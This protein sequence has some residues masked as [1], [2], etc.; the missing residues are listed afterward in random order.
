MLKTFERAALEAGKAIIKVFCN[1]CPVEMKADA[2]PVTIADQE[3]ERI[4]LA[5]LERDFPDIPVIAEE[6]VAA[7][8]IPDIA[9]KSFFLVDPLDG[10]REFLD[11]RNEFTVNIAYVE[12][13]IPIAGIVYAPALC[14]AFSG[15]RGSAEKLM[16]NENFAVVER[17]P[18]RVR[19]QP[20]ESVALASFRHDSP[21]TGL[22]LARH[23]ISKCTNMGSSLKFCLLAEGK[24]DVYPRFTRTMEWDT[25]A[26]D[27][28]LRAA[29]GSTVTMDG[30]PLIYGKTGVAGDVDFA[31][32]NFVS[33]GSI[34]PSLER[35]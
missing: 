11:K 14:T 9:G 35:A 5:Y 29:G 18:I 21:E 19:K 10:T 34:R 6:S 20:T 17:K 7:G 8:K 25:A 26:G 12:N 22:F 13:G 15:E 1:G 31:N 27:A 32:P 30:Q 16:I 3:A 24:A 23:A 33:W 4:I 28:V 2:S